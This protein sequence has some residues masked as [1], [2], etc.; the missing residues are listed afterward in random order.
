M[1]KKEQRLW[2]SMKR[3]APSKAWMIR[4]ENLVGDGLPDVWVAPGIWVELK[5]PDRP[6][7]QKTPLLS[8]YGL[9]PGQV[10][11][12]LKAATNGVKS[13]VLIRDDRN[14]IYMIPGQYAGHL[15]EMS[16]ADVALLSVA[17]SWSEVWG[18]LC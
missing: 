3:N 1:R 11:F 8:K 2:D 18:V 5:A 17:G 14:V 4:V 13:F 12:H 6:A 9:R 7:R 16:A 15:N 10:N